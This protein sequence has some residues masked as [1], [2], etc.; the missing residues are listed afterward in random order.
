MHLSEEERLDKLIEV[1]PEWILYG[2][3]ERRGKKSFDVTCKSGN[4]LVIE[5]LY[6]FEYSILNAEEGLVARKTEDDQWDFYENITN[7][8]IDE[9]VLAL[10]NELSNIAGDLAVICV[11]IRH[12]HKRR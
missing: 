2:F 9:L 5:W 7:E 8:M 11:S 1:I 3:T 12:Q 6:G 4:K 10:A